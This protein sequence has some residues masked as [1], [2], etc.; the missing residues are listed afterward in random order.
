MVSPQPS[1][2]EFT[3]SKPQSPFGRVDAVLGGCEARH[4][5]VVPG[6]ADLAD[7]NH[8]HAQIKSELGAR[9]QRNSC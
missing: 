2:T 4:A 6:G 7:W 5:N 3:L 9:E 1:A 8:R